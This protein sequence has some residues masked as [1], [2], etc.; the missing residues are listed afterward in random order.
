MNPASSASASA[1]F[2]LRM[3]GT[4]G[5]AGTAKRKERRA[6][7]GS[8]ALPWILMRGKERPAAGKVQ[9]AANAQSLVEGIKRGK[10]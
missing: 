4:A 10:K 3:R 5:T 6:N 7:R 9:R 1:S 2:P 8:N